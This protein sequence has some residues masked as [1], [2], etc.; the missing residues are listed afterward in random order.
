MTDETQ[1]YSLG[2]I[3]DLIVDAF[4]P[5]SFRELFYFGD[6]P[7]LE[8]IYHELN[9]RDSVSE[10]ATTAITYCDQHKLLSDLLLAIEQKRPEKYADFEPLLRRKAAGTPEPTYTP[11]PLPQT[12]QLPDLG[13]LPSGSH[14]PSA[15]SALLTGRVPTW[16]WLAA[17][18]A[19]VLLI[20][21]AVA[22]PRWIGGGPDA[23]A[24]PTWTPLPATATPTPTPPCAIAV[25]PE[26]AP[27]WNRAT[28]G[29]PD[30]SA[31]VVWSAWQPFEHGYMWWR[32]DSGSGSDLTYALFWQH[33]TNPLTGYWDT[34]GDAWRWDQVS[35]PQGHGL[36]P[37][38]GHYEPIH[39]FGFVWFD[40]LGGPASQIGWA[41][42]EEKGFCALVQPFEDG[43]I[44]RSSTVQ[45][46]QD[47]LFNYATQPSFAPLFFVLSDD[48]KWQ[49]Y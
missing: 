14:V 45:Y 1:E 15:R 26:L 22:I 4:D 42:D 21:L 5:D 6:N 41:T 3:H 39:G 37:P 11:P 20:L 19:A 12:D 17:G 28:L 49:R 27:A 48:G 30:E 9:P 24:T 8:P 35:F 32:S 2:T 43:L 40:K 10:M 46:C 25:D 16:L 7:E 18:G 33:G 31:H 29:C 44:F 13:P 23:T 36:T 47:E 38:A 34:G